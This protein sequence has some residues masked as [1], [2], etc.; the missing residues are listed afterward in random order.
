MSKAS[1]LNQ[2]RKLGVQL[3]DTHDALN[4]KFGA[5]HE[6]TQKSMWSYA[7]CFSILSDVENLFDEQALESEDE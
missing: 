5:A 6:L 7:R 4:N 2:I 3:A 1:I